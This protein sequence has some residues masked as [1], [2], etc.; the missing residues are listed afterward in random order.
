MSW[1]GIGTY[2]LFL[3]L[4]FLLL[5]LLLLTFLLL[6]LLLTFLLLLLTFLLLF[7]LFLLLLL[8]FLLLLLTLLLLLLLSYVENV[9]LLSDS[10]LPF[11]GPDLRRT[12]CVQEARHIRCGEGRAGCVWAGAE[13]CASLLRQRTEARR[14]LQHLVHRPRQIPRTSVDHVLS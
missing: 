6:L 2:P 9:L 12:G 5:L 3:L 13:T 11:R 14:G 10:G 8:T 7:L 1:P 4:T